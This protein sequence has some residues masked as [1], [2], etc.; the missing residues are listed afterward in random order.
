MMPQAPRIVVIG[1]VNMDLVATVDRFPRAGETTTAREFATN[2][3]GKGAN[4]AVAA[5]RL[6]ATVDFIGC[7]GDDGFGEQLRR[8][9][10]SSGVGCRELRTVRGVSSGTAWIHV[11]RRGE[12]SIT[13]VP[14]AN[15]EVTPEQ[16]EAARETI[17][18]ADRLLL[19]LEIPLETVWAAVELAGKLSV[20]VVLDPA[21]APAAPHPQL[22]R[23]DLL[24]PNETEAERLVG[25]PGLTPR[26]MGRVLGEAGAERVVLKRGASGALVLDEAGQSYEVSAFAVDAVDSTGAGDAFTAALA[27]RLAAADR[28]ADAVR[29][30]C[31]A[32]ALAA[33][34]HGA[35]QA[36]P[37]LD[38]VKSLLDNQSE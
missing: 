9:L 15:A 6:G 11:D 34:R 28:L 30:G 10:E 13:V 12:N 32:G 27:V 19:Q 18:R 7:V 37:S 21:P 14:G 16:I 22:C 8:S 4:Q 33:T 24:T 26:E 35:Q 3:G 38:E 1:S 20:P 25:S 31:A 17:A 29:F 23:V 2:P 36:M 5:A